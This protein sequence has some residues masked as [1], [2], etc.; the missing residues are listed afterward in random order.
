METGL[1]MIGVN[2]GRKEYPFAFSHCR[3]LLNAA[4]TDR[5]RADILSRLAEA[6]FA[7]N[8]R[9]YGQ[10]VLQ[11]LYD[12]HPYSEAAALARD[13]WGARP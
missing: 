3:R 5:Y 9:D 1:V 8:R 12:D 4:P 10:Q 7:M 6:A 11:K 2:L 13:R